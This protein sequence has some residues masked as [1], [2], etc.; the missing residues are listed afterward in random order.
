MTGLQIE[1]NL[2]CTGMKLVWQHLALQTISGFIFVHLWL[3]FWKESTMM[4][5]KTAVVVLSL[6]LSGLC[7]QAG[8]LLDLGQCRFRESSGFADDRSGL[9]VRHVSY[10]LPG[11]FFA[12]IPAAPGQYYRFSAQASGIGDGANAFYVQIVFGGGFP[13][14]HSASMEMPRDESAVPVEFV[15][16]APASWK[17][18]HLEVWLFS[19]V[20]GKGVVC[21]ELSLT[22]VERP[23][24]SRLVVT[25]PAYRQGIYHSH[26]VAAIAGRAVFYPE[27]SGISICLLQG[28]RVLA[29]SSGPEF[30]FA[31]AGEL[32]DGVY[33][34]R[35][36]ARDEHGKVV[37][38]S[39]EKITKWPP[40]PTEVVLSQD[41]QIYINGELFLPIFFMSSQLPDDLRAAAARRGV[42]LFIAYE[43]TTEA[44]LQRLDAASAHGYKIM[45]TVPYDGGRDGVRSV[46]EYRHRTMAR[47]TPEVLR[48]PALLGYMVKD[49]PAVK[50]EPL[51]P[52][53]G[54]AR[55]LREL[56]PYRPVWL[57]EAPHGSVQQHRMYSAMADLFGMD[58]YPVGRWNHG[59]IGDV[60]SLTCVGAVIDLCVQAVDNRKPIIG[61]LQ[62][63]AWNKNKP[64]Y[65]DLAQTRFMAYDAWFHG[66]KIP[67]YY[68][69]G[70][71]SSRDFVSVLFRMVEELRATVPIF[72]RGQ[73]LECDF[74]GPVRRLLV[75]DQGKRYL[76]AVNYTDQAVRAVIP[77][78]MPAGELAVWF[79]NRTVSLDNN[80]LED[81]FGPYAV[82]VY[83]EA[84]LAPAKAPDA[85]E[86]WRQA[87][88]PIVP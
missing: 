41:N 53:M 31:G 50:G 6:V 82:H 45:L 25:S 66:M 71:M 24:E 81:S 33:V 9:L 16:Q 3:K 5:M 87:V 73:W 42:N 12:G 21:R 52:L 76:F 37:A 49:E 63:Y 60:K 28:E 57:N 43:T 86:A 7:V 14:Y 85:P 27:P 11:A 46:D 62:A 26:P 65:P 55:A 23:P 84:S 61:I 40:S 48:H 78:R 36:V 4:S 32:A 18:K 72:T 20:R 88:V 68:G 10:Y 75:E 35:A 2:N 67:G 64:E 51:A 34:I 70:A 58:I 83:S 29:Q 77:A 59:S 17:A 19:R 15:F 56:D 79:E 54:A 47:L 39:E 22:P 44:I 69:V 1:R 30:S 80:R 8:N 13:K 74:T 38:T